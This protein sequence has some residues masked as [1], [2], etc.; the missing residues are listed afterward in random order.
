MLRGNTHSRY[1]KF[2]NL[3]VFLALLV[4]FLSLSVHQIVNF[5]IWWHLKTGRYILENLS[6]PRSDIYTFT[7]PGSRWIDLHWGFQA[8]V[9]AVY[10]VAGPDGLILFQVLVLGTAFL[11]A[12]GAPSR[13]PPLAVSAPFIMFALF[14]CEERFIVRPGMITLLFTALYLYGLGRRSRRLISFFPLFQI[15]WVNTGGLFILGLV[16][17]YLHL[18][19]EA[20]QALLFRGQREDGWGHLRLVCAVSLLSTAAC[21]INPFG[22]EGLTFPLKLFSRIGGARNLY[23]MTIGEFQQPIPWLPAAGPGLL[24]K[25]TAAA[26]S[27]LRADVTHSVF[28]FKVLCAASLACFVLNVRRA[29][30]SSMLIYAAFLYLA[31]SARRNMAVFS[32]A[33]LAVSIENLYFLWEALRR[34]RGLERGLRLAA[35]AVV[36][37]AVS[38][39]VPAILSGAYYVEDNTTKRFGPGFSR[40]MY[41]VGA[42]EFAAAAPIEGNIFNDL[43]SGGLLAWKL[44]P[45]KKIFIDGRLE[46]MP[47][48]FYRRYLEVID[49]PG[50]NFAA[51]AS[52]Y[53]IQLVVINHR[54]VG[55]RLLTYL[56]ESP[57]WQPVYFD[58]IGIVFCRAGERNS[59]FIDDHLV[60]F[61]GPFDDAPLQ[62]GFPYGRFYRGNFLM[63]I[64]LHEPA[65][66]EYREGLSIFPSYAPGYSA[67]GKMYEEEGRIDRARSLYGRA[68]EIDP[69]LFEARLNMG[70]LELSSGFPAAARAQYLRAL[71]INPFSVDAHVN[72]G[73][74]L[75]RTGDG[76]GAIQQYERALALD[77]SCEAAV[78]NLRIVA[79]KTALLP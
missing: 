18:A 9:Y 77:P 61:S 6:V 28:F 11:L 16:I 7:Y 24:P 15:I 51:C 8:A 3:L 79:E 53:D 13:R 78:R 69:R 55:K 47:E 29:R 19:G 72:M 2:L 56:H 25:A 49:S 27:L 12:C 37:L 43:S 66:R 45:R 50:E 59:S 20:V 22:L 33:A 58:E 41:P 68:L 38:W 23:S 52:Q 75:Y 26:R 46:V 73:T 44:Y 30:I 64:G 60:D 1:W 74:A 67:M 35:G 10:S 70:N 40:M 17:L 34:R 31:L 4:L 62:G 5:D 71:A 36:L 21:L 54:A 14:V 57:L 48:D 63:T 42:A 76:A 32:L 65:L 39:R